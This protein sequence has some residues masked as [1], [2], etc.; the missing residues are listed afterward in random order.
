MTAI[1]PRAAGLLAI[2][3]LVLTSL[4]PG[5]VMIGGILA[6]AVAFELRPRRGSP[7]RH[8]PQRPP[9]PLALLAAIG[10]TLLEMV[11]GSVRT[12]RFCLGDSSRSGLVEIPRAGRSRHGVAFWGVLTGESP[13]EV[14]VDVD[15]DRDVLIVH[16][17]D[18][19]DPDE[20]R[21]RHRREY[22]RHQG[23]AVP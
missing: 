4:K 8:G 7:R 21:R 14:V 18:A 17:V 20:V 23:K 12:A 5:D 15:D 3:L 13:D 16:L 10:S 11:R 2:Y 9:A 19:G 1:L 6:L 22:E